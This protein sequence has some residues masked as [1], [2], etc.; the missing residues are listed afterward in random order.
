MYLFLHIT[1]IWCLNSLVSCKT[2]WVFSQLLFVFS[3]MEIKLISTFLQC[4]T[5][6]RLKW[7]VVQILTETVSEHCISLTADAAWQKDTLTGLSVLNHYSSWPV[8]MT[9]HDRKS[10]QRVTLYCTKNYTSV[11]RVDHHTQPHLTETLFAGEE[12]TEV[13][14]QATHTLL[15]WSSDAQIIRKQLQQKDSVTM[16]CF[17]DT[18]IMEMII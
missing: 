4:K 10:C 8:K 15:N 12:K 17:C 6:R 9:S 5:L 18:Q 11:K 2:M 13:K 1:I 7:R 14:L 16:I 3:N